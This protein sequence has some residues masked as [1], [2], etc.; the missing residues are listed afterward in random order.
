MSRLQSV[1]V[2]RTLAIISVIA[3]HTR[4]FESPSAPI[5]ATLDVA[6]FVNQVAR[7]AVPFFFVISG[8]FWASK[9]TDERQLFAPT[10]KR[11]KRI[12]FI[13]SAWSAIYL[14]P[15]DIIDA[16]AYGPLGPLKTIYWNLANAV[17]EPL[18]T[19]L[20]G[21]KV[22]LWFLMGLMCSLIISSAFLRFNLKW[23]LIAVAA[24]LYSI[25]LAGKA[26]ADTP[27]GFHVGFNFRDGPFFSLIFFVTGYLLQRSGPKESWLF[28]GIFLSV[29]GVFMHFAELLAIQRFWG[30]T[31]NQDYVIGT[32]FLGV[33][34]ALIA[35]SNT[36]KLHFPTIASVGP[37]VLG[38]YA[39]HF[40]FVAILKPL[41][42]ELSGSS[43]W[44]VSYVVA[45][46][47]LS[48]F[49]TFILSK[50]RLTRR[51]VV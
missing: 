19:I 35:L 36:K 13:F 2:L 1:D 40:A 10:V 27:I 12:A 41:D 37:L 50:Y 26:Y 20:E 15:I 32:Y 31:M 45:V 49:M 8:Y 38:I 23:C 14:L 46:F 11:V 5:G 39:S 7:F 16:F 18:T 48:Y 6:T 29:L 51:L 24:T 22:H 4:P 30:T 34:V 33:G 42:R 3:I 21:T 9:F 25:G 44:D 43:I 17:N 47:F 28:K